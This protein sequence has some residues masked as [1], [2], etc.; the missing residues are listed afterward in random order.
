MNFIKSMKKEHKIMA[1]FFTVVALVTIY[2]ICTTNSESSAQTPAASSPPPITKNNQVKSQTKDDD[3]YN[4]DS[5]LFSLETED[6]SGNEK[7]NKEE[8]TGNN[9]NDA[10]YKVIS[11]LQQQ[12]YDLE[13]ASDAMSS[14][15]ISYNEKISMLQLDIDSQKKEI[16][17]L[18]NS[19]KVKFTSGNKATKTTH[20]IPAKLEKIYDEETAE[21]SLKNGRTYIVKKGDDIEGQIKILGINYPD[22]Y[23]ETSLGVLK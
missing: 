22:E 15:I 7:P 17:L 1:V 9:D 3:I 4:E 13:K 20:T 21:I 16:Q 8:T 6:E 11:N 23:V 18:K 14:Q 12:L 19:S 5:E 10:M 2:L